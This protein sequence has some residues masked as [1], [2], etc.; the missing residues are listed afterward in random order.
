[1]ARPRLTTILPV[2]LSLPTLLPA[3]AIPPESLFV[4]GDLVQAQTAFTS[5][6]TVMPDDRLAVRRLATLALWSNHL[7]DAIE[8]FTALRNADPSNPAYAAGLA[9]ALYQAKHTAEAAPLFRELGD[10]AFA[11]TLLALP[12]P[13]VVS[14]PHAGARLPFLE[15]A[16]LPVVRVTVDG[17]DAL[18][19]IDTGA[20]DV[21][22]DPTFAARI[23]AR[24]FGGRGNRS[25]VG[26]IQLDAA[27]V[28]AVPVRL[29]PTSRY[30]GAA[31]GAPV[32]G[33]IGTSLLMQF[34][35]T[36]DFGSG[37]LV[38][39]SRDSHSL[40]GTAV[41]FWLIGGF[42]VVTD[43]AAR[44]EP[45]LFFD[46]GLALRGAMLAPAPELLA[47]AHRTAPADSG[48]VRLP[49]LRVGP[50]DR[51]DVP[52]LA[53]VFPPALAHAFGVR[54][55]GAVSSAF[56]A[57]HRVTIDPTAMQLVIDGAD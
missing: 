27:T 47:A 9:R 34:R 19:I 22:L 49:E 53:N 30:A 38:L 7:D 28:R 5:R 40:A 11:Q 21:I 15:D 24:A 37:A 18:F 25:V 48:L 12:S 2:L 1:M 17:T 6:L 42:I 8:R 52:A 43:T 39:A 20:S 35:A 51:R 13:Y 56:F 54:I 55:G 3:Q 46:T 32:A 14:L 23:G 33:V 4:R 16:P 57:G 31:G 36:L 10:T 45:P 26:V 41:P 44:N 50:I 29:A